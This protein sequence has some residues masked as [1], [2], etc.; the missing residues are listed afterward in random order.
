MSASEGDSVDEAILVL[1]GAV[2]GGVVSALATV[3]ASRRQYVRETRVEIFRVLLP[4][5]HDG[6]AERP[7]PPTDPDARWD[8]LF[9][10][11]Q[12][13]GGRDWRRVAGLRFLV[14]DW[15]QCLWQAIGDSPVDGECVCDEDKLAEARRQEVMVRRV[16]SDYEIWL[17]R[18][19]SGMGRQP[20][21]LLR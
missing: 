10:A 19:V 11:A 16:L 15:R 3:W 1:A 12:S 18:R 6:G 20:H 7:R 8:E 9:R 17:G 5:V 4:T 21:P 2:V 13:L 14:S